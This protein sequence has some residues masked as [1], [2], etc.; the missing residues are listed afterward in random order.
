MRKSKKQRKYDKKRILSN[1]KLLKKYPWLA[2]DFN[3]WDA[4]IWNYRKRVGYKWTWYDDFPRGWRKAFGKMMIEDIDQALKKAG[5]EVRDNFMVSQIKEKFGELRFYH[6][7][8]T[9]EVDDIVEA[10]SVLSRNI[11]VHCGKPDVGYLTDGWIMPIC[12]ECFKDLS[13]TKTYDE[14]I[15][16]DRKMEE[17]RRFRRSLP[18][19]DGWKE[20][21]VD[22]SEYAEKVRIRYVKRNRKRV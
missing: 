18:G 22:I 6:Y 8:G 2:S 19:E 11:C 17:V 5:K 21:V 9:R 4:R 16:E 3:P 13:T 14:A 20:Y 10:Y 12:E 1:R 15:S 7:G